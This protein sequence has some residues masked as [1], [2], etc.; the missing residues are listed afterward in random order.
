MKSSAGSRHRA[1]RAAMQA[2]YQWELTG[3]QATEIENHFLRDERAQPLDE[4]YFRELVREVPG[5]HDEL[6]EALQPCLDR[7]L[8]S[9]DPVERAILQIAAYELLFRPDV[10]TRVVLNEAVELAKNFGAE[11]GYKF[12]NGVLDKLAGRAREKSPVS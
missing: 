2:L 1:R 5:R 10:P 12:V 6:R 7:Q 8:G 3:Q 4:E 11:H 9:V